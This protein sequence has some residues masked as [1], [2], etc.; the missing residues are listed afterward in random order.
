MKLLH[1]YNRLNILATILVLFIA[2]VC[3]YL[4]LSYVLIKQIDKDL[5]LEEQEVRDFVH[6][7]NSLP[8]SANYKDQQMKFAAVGNSIP[9]RKISSVTIFDSSENE[10]QPIRRLVFPL[11]VKGQNYSVTIIKS[12][13]ETEDLVRLIVMLTLSIVALLLL[14][15]FI[16]NRFVLRK[17]WLPFNKTLRGLKQF[18]VNNNTVIGHND[19]N[20]TEFKELDDAVIM[21]M[22][23]VVNDYNSLKTFTENASHESQTPLAVINSKLEL[24]IQAENFSEQQVQDIQ[25]IY[26]EIGRLSKLNQSLLLLT[27]IDNYQFS[28]TCEVDLVQ[29]IN[30]QLSNYEELLA[31]KGITLVKNFGDVVVVDMNET[32]AQV[33]ISNLITNSI[34]HNVDGGSIHINAVQK[35]LSFTNTGT[36]LNSK[37]EELFQRFKK[38][39]VNAES[40]GLGLSIV[41]KICDRYNFTVSY[42]HKSGIHTLTVLFP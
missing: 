42:I 13:Q 6:L 24:L 27:K 18:N 4:I 34:K 17:L 5:R 37:P 12:Q 28:E 10:D 14:A 31:A 16:I 3:Y 22:E 11:A 25:T 23:R 26:D 9:A 7:N 20:I 30:R 36:F 33:L 35:S 32:M 8:P 19:T 2:G 29:M 41:K 21:M 40:L 1:K 39:K 15:L 38:D